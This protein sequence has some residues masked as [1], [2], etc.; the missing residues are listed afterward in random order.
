MKY[1]NMLNI[2]RS[3]WLALGAL[4]LVSQS[5]FAAGTAPAA[6]GDSDKLDI[7]KL[8]DKYWSAKDDD[9]TVVQ[10]RAFSKA[11]RFYITLQGGIPIN[12]PY[13]TGSWTGASLG[14]HFSERYGMEL[15]YLA[16]NFHDNDATANFQ[17]QGAYP[18]HN[19]AKSITDL[20]FNYI[21]LYAKMSFLDKKIIYFDMGLG[22]ILG[23]S[24][25][26]QNSDAGNT[27]Q[28]AF[29]YGL[30]IYQHYFL[31]EHWA[32][33]F[34]YRNTWTNEDRVH[35]HITTG[36]DRSLGSKSINDSALMI[37]LTFFK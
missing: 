19:T 9:F 34:D 2:T 1:A 14:Y 16:A 30:S 6:S 27:D 12:D 22:L 4:V 23:T 28:S 29:S 26:S 24:A 36:Q 7:K 3:A 32:I 11:K 35:Y 18:N 25:Y 5:A 8:E 20:Q 33:K 37:G 13:S 31:S 10:N 15:N 17:G 21:P